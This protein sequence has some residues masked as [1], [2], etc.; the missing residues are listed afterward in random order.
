MCA[1]VRPIEYVSLVEFGIWWL[2][3]IRVLSA[4][5]GQRQLRLFGWCASP[6][7]DY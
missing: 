7:S 1:H 2:I 3:L 4:A 6:N 5:S